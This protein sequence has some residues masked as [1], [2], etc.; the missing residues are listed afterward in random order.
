MRSRISIRVGW[1]VGRLVRPLSKQGFLVDGFIER[2][3][4]LV[5]CI[6]GSKDLKISKI[7]VDNMQI[8]LEVTPDENALIVPLRYLFFSLLQ[9]VLIPKTEKHFTTKRLFHT[10]QNLL[11]EMNL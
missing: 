11:I 5:E 1:L 6:M 7:Y 4:V 10:F 9:I 2:W 3:K 8:W